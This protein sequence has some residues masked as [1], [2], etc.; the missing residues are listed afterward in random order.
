MAVASVFPREV[1]RF[2]TP[3]N[4]GIAAASMLVGALPLVIYNIAQPLET[5]RSHGQFDAGAVAVKAQSLKATMDG[6]IFFG[7]MTRLEPG[8]QPGVARH[9]YQSLSI[10]MNR[11][12]G[13][14]Y[15]NLTV[16]AL[17][18]C[19]LALPL[20]WRTARK[21]VLFGAVACVGTWTA[22]AFT[23]G[24]G[25]A[26]HH[27]VL[28]W[29]FHFLVISA[30]VSRARLVP[31]VAVTAL[32]CGS[33]LA[34]T[35]HYYADLIRN[36]PGIRWT[37]AMDPLQQYLR[38]LDGPRIIAADWGFLETMNLLTKGELITFDADLRSDSTI[39]KA[40]SDPDN[41]FIRFTPPVAFEPATMAFIQ[42]V[43]QGEN[44]EQEHITT[45]YDLS[46]RPTFDVFRFRKVHL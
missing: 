15:H 41:V 46:G 32:L 14:P 45:I 22:M 18:A 35:N 3:A 23:A 44:Y 30:V 34:V 40:I 11:R 16:F 5:F 39:L 4:I 31:A 26:A 43:A 2:L 29:P 21:P 20:L 7:F 6:Y 27:A 38:N 13:D 8:P 36:G 28:L 42:R 24:G 25:E 19:I 1:R 12:L 37:D 33:N 10:A 17:L 9:W